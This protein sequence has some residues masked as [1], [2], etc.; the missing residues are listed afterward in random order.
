M[1]YQ[2][3]Q[4][5]LDTRVLT[6]TINRP[7]KLNALNR[8]TLQELYA[9]MID[10][11]GDDDV[12]IIVITAAG[13]KAFV[14]GADIAEI[15]EQ[16]ATEARAFS[17]FGQNLMLLIQHFDKPVIAAING[18]ALGGGLELALACHLRLASDNARLGLPEIKLGIMPGFGGTQRLVRLTGST[19]ALEMTLTG[20]PISAERAK[21]LNLVNRVTAPADLM[22]AATELASRLAGA[23]PEAV[24]GI[25][26][27]TLQGAETD[28]QTGLA[29]ETAR[30]ALCCATEDMQEGTAAFLEKR[31]PEFKGR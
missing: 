26:Q 31:K 22:D 29:L 13:E 4:T 21:E 8:H 10:A 2:N 5:Q 12:R 20:E 24:R 27:A 9:A 25:L 14:A 1:T 3:L 18:V 17:E 11:H 6:I 23:A 28:L 30:F 16:N 15:R 7:D 19:V